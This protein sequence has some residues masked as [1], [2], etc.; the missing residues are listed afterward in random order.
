MDS[1]I[2][3]EFTI[4]QNISDTDD[5]RISEI[6]DPLEVSIDLIRM[7]ISIT[8]PKNGS[9]EVISELQHRGLRLIDKDAPNCEI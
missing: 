3:L 5:Q 9:K 2:E 4:P 6:L 1:N 8:I 7:R